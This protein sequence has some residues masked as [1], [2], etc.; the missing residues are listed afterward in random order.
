MKK[1]IHPEYHT[2][3]EVT[4]ACGAKYVVSSTLD[5]LNVEVCAACHP[6]FTGKQRFLDTSRRLEK[7]AEKMKKQEEAAKERTG[8]KAKRARRAER[9]A[10]EEAT[11]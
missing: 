11:K 7:F 1:E 8:K 3:L 4:C 9:K 10:Q 5:N 6:F 2:D